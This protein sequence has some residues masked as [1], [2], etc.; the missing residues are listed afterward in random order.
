[1]VRVPILLG[2]NPLAGG[3]VVTAAVV[4]VV[5]AIGTRRHCAGRYARRYAAIGI[6][7]ASPTS[8]ITR[9]TRAS[10]QA[11]DR[12]ARDGVNRP[13]HTAGVGA[14]RVATAGVTAPRIAAAGV[15]APCV[16]ASGETAGAAVETSGAL[17]SFK[18]YQFP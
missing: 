6:I 10:W 11:C 14:P 12:T 3:V 17:I 5:V 13:S 7:S 9:I 4:V 2:A 16:A 8:A 1:M 18:L 15:A